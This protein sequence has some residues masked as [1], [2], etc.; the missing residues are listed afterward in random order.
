MAT[1]EI[2]QEKKMVVSP[3]LKERI[4]ATNGIYYVQCVWII[5]DK[6]NLP[7]G[8]RQNITLGS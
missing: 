4:A 7:V 3:T 5:D 6:T 1:T 8:V 2:E